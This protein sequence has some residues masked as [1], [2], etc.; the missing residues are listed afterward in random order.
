[1]A[2]GKTTVKPLSIVYQNEIARQRAAKK[3]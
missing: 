3:L 2:A 1:L